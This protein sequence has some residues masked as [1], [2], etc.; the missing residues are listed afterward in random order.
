MSLPTVYG[1]AAK[2]EC[3]CTRLLEHAA[4]ILRV[5]LQIG[6]PVGNGPI[7]SQ[8]DY[9]FKASRARCRPLAGSFAIFASFAA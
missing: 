9:P 5:V 4:E 8:D 7:E 3:P 6:Q 2:Q 1:N